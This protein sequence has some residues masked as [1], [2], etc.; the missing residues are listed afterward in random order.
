MRPGRGGGLSVGPGHPVGGTGDGAYSQLTTTLVRGA[1][2]LWQYIPALKGASRVRY[3]PQA[4]SRMDFGDDGQRY[5]NSKHKT[6]HCPTCGGEPVKKTPGKV[7]DGVHV[8]SRAGAAI[9]LAVQGSGWPEMDTD[10]ETDTDVG[11]AEGLPE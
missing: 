4:R 5:V 10:H 1:L 9:S 2:C 3:K 6:Y 11:K 8:H 7:G